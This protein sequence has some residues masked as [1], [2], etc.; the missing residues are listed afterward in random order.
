[1]GQVTL[2]A[3]ICEYFKANVDMSYLGREFEDSS[4]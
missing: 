4:T 1:M 3:P 2:T